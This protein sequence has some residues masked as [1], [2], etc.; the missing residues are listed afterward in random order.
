MG[1]YQRVTVESRAACFVHDLFV[2]PIP[3]ENRAEA[4]VEVWNCDSLRRPARLVLSVHG[5]NFEACVIDNLEC[6][7]PGPLGPRVNYFRFQLDLP[8]HRLWEPDS[9]WLYQLQARLFSED[10]ELLDTRFRQFGMRSFRMDEQSVPHGRMFLNGR[11]IR[12]RGANTMGFEQLDVM[13]GDWNQLVDDLLLAKMCH[14]NFLRLTQRPVQEEVY[15]YCD[16]LG[17]MTQTDLPLFGKMRR[18]QFHEGVRQAGEM[19]RLVRSHPCNVIVSYINEPFPLSWGL[20]LRRHLS[21]TEL[22]SFFIACDQTVRLENPDRVI[23]PVDG[24]YEPPGPGLPDNHCYC[25]WYNGHGLSVGKLHRGY[26]QPVKPGWLYAC[27][28]FGAE[29]LDPVDVMRSYYPREWLPQPDENESQWTPNRIVKAQSGNMH[30]NFYDT[31]DTLIGWV[32]ASCR[33]QEWATKIMTEAFRRDVRMNSFAIHLFIDAFPSGWMKTIMD[34]ERTP[35]PAFWAYREALT[36]LMVNLRTDR[37]TLFGGETAE[38]EAWICNDLQ[39]Q[40]DTHLIWH[41]ELNGRVLGSGAVEA[42]VP[43]CT[44]VCQGLIR[45]EVPSVKARSTLLVHLGLR[46]AGETIVHDTH[47]SITVFPREQQ[48]PDASKVFILTEEKMGPAS[49]LC[50]ALGISLRDWHPE[51]PADST[52]LIDDPGLLKNNREIL[53]EQVLRGATVVLL[54]AP[55]GE[56]EIAGDAIE[57]KAC[58]MGPVNFVSRKTAHPLVER[59]ESEDFRLWFNPT[60][61]CI[62]PLLETSFSHPDWT[63][64]LTTG[65][66]GFG[67]NW[68]PSLATAEKI[69]GAGVWRICNV[70]L[71]DFAATNPVADSFARR[72]LSGRYCLP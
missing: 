2:R 41:A 21:R 70:K 26:W 49:R 54:E 24:D 9:P 30:F 34:F 38:I 62:A 4:W 61:D 58:G 52:I 28:E 37:F 48:I 40:P 11:E 36:P 19:E 67:G 44:S 42:H 56:W 69:Q 51:T 14:M 57:V 25:C 31:P 1:I 8:N 16:R 68:V 46:K 50:L 71:A 6:V 53:E 27:G 20:E 32:D 55:V 35:K 29:G 7:L 59:Y 17:L 72:M 15:D 23:K 66:G 13:K 22:E 5:Q 60:E 12:L 43:A 18:S 63:P 47:V 3:E 10:G 64:I 45:F 33:H 65:T 39:E